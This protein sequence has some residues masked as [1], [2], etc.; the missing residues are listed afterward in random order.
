MCKFIVLYGIR[1]YKRYNVEQKNQ[2]KYWLNLYEIMSVNTAK[3][4]YFFGFYTE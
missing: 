2:S 4:D 3:S 1:F